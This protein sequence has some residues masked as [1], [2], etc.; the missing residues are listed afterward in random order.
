MRCQTARFPL[1]PAI[2]T[3]GLAISPVVSRGLTAPDNA[4]II[5]FFLGMARD[6]GAALSRS[7]FSHIFHRILLRERVDE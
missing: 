3:C 7:R 2:G 5:I 4:S 6:A 1:T